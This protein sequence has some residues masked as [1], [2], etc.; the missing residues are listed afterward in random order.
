[1]P[2]KRNYRRKRYYKRKPQGYSRYMTWQNAHRALV[3]AKH[4]KT[5][6][7]VERKVVDITQSGATFSSSTA[8]V[9]DL[10]VCAQGD[11]D[12]T[13]DGA[14]MK[15][16]RH[17]IRGEITMNASATG[18]ICRIIVCMKKD[19]GGA[20][21]SNL[22][23][24]CTSNSTRAFYDRN[25]IYNFRIL[26]DK[27]FAL[28]SDRPNIYFRYAKKL[29]DVVRFD[30]TGAT[31]ADIARNGVFILALSDQ[32]TNTPTIKYHS[33]VTFVDN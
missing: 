11:T 1:M 31:V 9:G 5:L 4:L 33:R 7:N 12:L 13:R 15:M 19:T 17:A 14:Q 28:S 29:K 26:Y 25:H 3:L 30:G 22:G 23:S 6:V 8:H 21:P 27:T 2:Y 20:A 18:T 32:A 24:I 10:N 16:I